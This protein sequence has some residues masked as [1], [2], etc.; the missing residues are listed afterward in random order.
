MLANKLFLVASIT[1]SIYATNY[2]SLLFN[3]NCITCHHETKS[4]SAPSMV[5]I[6][7]NYLRAFPNKK[8][9][10]EYMSRWI[11]KPKK[12][13]SIM[14]DAINKYSLMPELAYEME[15]LEEISDYVYETD[16]DKVK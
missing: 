6:R 12:E 13:T 2:G 10:V 15:T 4:I 7:E 1:T 14:L 9:F 3:G 8:E 16:F 11:K 5:E